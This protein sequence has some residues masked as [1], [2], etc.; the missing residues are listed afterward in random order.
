MARALTPGEDHAIPPL[1]ERR[2]IRRAS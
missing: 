2:L 1:P